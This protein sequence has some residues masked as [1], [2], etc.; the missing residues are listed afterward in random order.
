VVSIFTTGQPWPFL[1]SFSNE[2][3]FFLS[4]LSRSDILTPGLSFFFCTSLVTL[5]C[6]ATD[7]RCSASG[8]SA[9]SILLL[10]ALPRTSASQPRAPWPLRY[11]LL[12][13]SIPLHHSYLPSLAKVPSQSRVLWSHFH[14]VTYLRTDHST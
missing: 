12:I 2:F 4:E 10:H 6:I 11:Y 1:L 13:A 7:F 5:T 8:P 14:S 9:S 3:P